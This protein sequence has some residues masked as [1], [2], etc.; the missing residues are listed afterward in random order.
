[1]RG[2]PVSDYDRARSLFQARRYAEAYPLLQAVIQE[3]PTDDQARRAAAACLYYTADWAGA[4]RAYRDILE[5]HPNDA[6]AV[7]FLT[8]SLERQGRQ[9]ETSDGEARRSGHPAARDSPTPDLPT[10]PF[11]T[12][13]RTKWRRWP[14][15]TGATTA[16][17]FARPH[18]RL[19]QVSA[20][21]VD[22]TARQ[23]EMSGLT[24]A[25]DIGEGDQVEVREAS[26][27]SDGVLR[28]DQVLN[29]STAVLVSSSRGVAGLWKLSSAAQGRGL[30]IVGVVVPVV[31]LLL[32]GAFLVAVFHAAGG[33]PGLSGQEPAISLTET[34]GPPGTSLTVHGKG[35]QPGETVK[36]LLLADQIAEVRVG[37]DGSFDV[38]AQIPETFRFKGQFPL[39]ATGQTSAR[40]AEEPFTVT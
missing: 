6:E 30:A 12:S 39:T 16:G 9:I 22:G 37:G 35:F 33:I 14:C 2:T 21:V 20:P 31:I 1:M 17:D 28:T 40:H 26:E 34:S 8:V 15:Q 13:R 27:G 10:S 32:L 3:N 18:H 19:P 29:R 24:I 4:E 38:R 5:R 23:V 7:H 36:V 11:P 25:G